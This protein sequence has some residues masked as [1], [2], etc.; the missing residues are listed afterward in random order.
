MMD[1]RSLHVAARFI[2]LIQMAQNIQYQCDPMKASLQ[3]LNT[4][5]TKE[6]LDVLKRTAI[7]W[8]PELDKIQK[9]IVQEIVERRR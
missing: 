7:F 3:A 1:W 8:M 9:S 6:A 2:G 5:G 4:I